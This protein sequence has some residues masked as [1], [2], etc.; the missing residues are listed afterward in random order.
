MVIAIG[1]LTD[2][3]YWLQ[4]GNDSN[5]PI[6]PCWDKKNLSAWLGSG[7]SHDTYSILISNWQGGYLTVPYTESY[8][9]Q[10]AAVLNEIKNNDL[11]DHEDLKWLRASLVWA[12]KNNNRRQ[13]AIDWLNHYWPNNSHAASEYVVSFGPIEAYENDFWFRIFSYVLL[14]LSWELQDKFTEYLAQ[15]QNFLETIW[16]GDLTVRSRLYIGDAV[17]M[18][19]QLGKFQASGWSRPTSTT[20]TQEYGSVQQLF[21]N[22]MRLKTN[23]MYRPSYNVARWEETSEKDFFELFLLHVGMHE[24]SHPIKVPWYVESFGEKN[25]N[26]F[27]TFE[28]IKTD[29]MVLAR[30][31]HLEKLW[32]VSWGTTKRLLKVVVTNNLHMSY[33]CERSWWK[34]RREYDKTF[35]YFLWRLQNHM[36]IDEWTMIHLAW[37]DAVI[38]E[39]LQAMA[40]EMAGLMRQ[41]DYVEFERFFG[42][43]QLAERKKDLVW[44]LLLKNVAY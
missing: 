26:L 28:E 21:L 1:N 14:K 9:T 31:A 4:L 36:G 23:S 20:L 27:L 35:D 8:A 3:I 7:N 10:L 33:V 12:L 42:E 16:L 30:V 22:N 19:W 43:L 2:T 29:V 18:S 13:L 6:Y 25:N 32:L 15:T 38:M 34:K 17:N 44:K 11:F 5:A 37:E 40:Q 39:E 41:S 24:A